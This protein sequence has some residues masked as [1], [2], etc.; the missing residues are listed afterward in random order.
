[1][2][3]LIILE[4]LGAARALASH[5]VAHALRSAFPRGAAFSRPSMCRPSGTEEFG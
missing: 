2:I 4:R 5:A 1:M 3:L